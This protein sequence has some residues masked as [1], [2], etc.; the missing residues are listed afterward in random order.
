MESL[1]SKR[2]ESGITEYIGLRSRMY[3]ILETGG[4]EKRTANGIVKSI[5]VKEFRHEI[6]KTI[7][8]NE[9]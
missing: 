4:K 9:W 1:K 8:R 5:F 6:Y 7:L 2:L 3:S